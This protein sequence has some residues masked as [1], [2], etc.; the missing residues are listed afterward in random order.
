MILTPRG[1]ISGISTNHCIGL[2]STL[3]SHGLEKKVEKQ[4]LWPL[5]NLPKHAIQTSPA[6]YQTVSRECLKR[7]G[8]DGKDHRATAL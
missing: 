5:L 2:G 6:I 3:G 1:R 7:V 8:L 4:L